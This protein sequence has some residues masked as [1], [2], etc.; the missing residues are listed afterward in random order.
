MTDEAQRTNESRSTH[1]K[2][3][4]APHHECEQCRGEDGHELRTTADGPWPQ[5][6]AVFR[7]DRG[8][9]RHDLA[10]R[11]GADASKVRRYEDGEGSL[12]PEMA[13]AWGHA[14]QIPV[15]GV[16]ARC[17]HA[18]PE[19]LLKHPSSLRR[20]RGETQESLGRKIGLTAKEVARLERGGVN[21]ASALWQGWAETLRI[22]TDMLTDL[23]GRTPATSQRRSRRN[24]APSQRRS[25]N[26]PTRRSVL[27]ED[28]GYTARTLGR[29]VGLSAQQIGRY[30]R[31]EIEIGKVE[32]KRLARRL[33]VS[34]KALKDGTEEGLPDAVLRERS[35]LRRL[36]GTGKRTVAAALDIDVAE[37]TRIETD[38]YVPESELVRWAQAS[39]VRVASALATNGPVPVRKI[40][41]ITS[42]EPAERYRQGW[43]D[44]GSGLAGALGPGLARA[45]RW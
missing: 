9:S 32:L 45:Q 42:C 20:L 2:Q 24:T 33:G 18:L 44:I 21:P 10:E 5:R 22:S 38:S 6:L 25:H 23:A 31:A 12:R 7:I 15:K 4:E 43:L 19:T 41:P 3:N 34:V 27:R 14:V 17:R 29:S 11:I 30:E 39:N 37:V 13:Q 28:R 36:G 8:L 40:R 16:L 26:T 1:A 35:S